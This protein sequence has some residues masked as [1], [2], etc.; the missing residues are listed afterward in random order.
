MGC[1][2]HAVNHVADRDLL[3]LLAHDPDFRAA[4]K[5]FETFV[6]TL[7]AKVSEVDSTVPELPTKDL[8]CRTWFWG[9]VT[10]FSSADQVF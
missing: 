1:I 6:E 9:L 4:K 10:P 2:H 3:F 5:D 7:S 8:V